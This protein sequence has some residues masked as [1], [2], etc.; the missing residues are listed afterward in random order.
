MIAPVLIFHAVLFALTFGWL[1]WL[2][3]ERRLGGAELPEP[4]LTYTATGTLPTP[5]EA[6]T[7]LMTPTLFYFFNRGSGS[8]TEDWSYGWIEYPQVGT[9]K[10]RAFL[11][12]G[13]EDEG[14]DYSDVEEILISPNEKEHTIPVVFG[15]VD[16]FKPYNDAFGHVQAKPGKTTRKRRGK[17]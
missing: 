11:F 7:L 16:E 6:H 14:K 8:K 9:H 1:F 10:G 17:R 12:R 5:A 2:T 15:D 4:S 3:T 13:L